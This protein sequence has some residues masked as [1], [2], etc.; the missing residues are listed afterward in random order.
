MYLK[1]NMNR[2]GEDF[3]YMHTLIEVVAGDADTLEQR[4]SAMETLCTCA[5]HN[6]IS[7]AF[8]STRAEYQTV[9]TQRSDLERQMQ[10]KKSGS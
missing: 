9:T 4:V 1:E 8:Q 2:G 3:Y 5:G 6:R 7:V 10:A